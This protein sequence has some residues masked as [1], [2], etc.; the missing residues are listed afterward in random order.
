VWCWWRCVWGWG[1]MHAGEVLST[2]LAKHLSH[3][4]V[5][6]LLLQARLCNRCGSQVSRKKNQAAKHGQAVPALDGEAPQEAQEQPALGASPEEEETAVPAMQ[7]SRQTPEAP[8]AGAAAGADAAA[9]A[10]SSAPDAERKQCA[11][12]GSKTTSAGRWR[13]HPTTWVRRGCSLQCWCCQ[14][15]CG[16]PPAFH[17]LRATCRPACATAAAQKSPAR[18]RSLRQSLERQQPQCME[19]LLAR[20]LSIQCLGRQS[21]QRCFQPHCLRVGCQLQLE[22]QQRP[23]QAVCQ[24]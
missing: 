16:R 17:F 14:Q 6:H 19:R 21:Q 22:M 9:L 4:S 15:G 1:C 10:V 23:G 2:H 3:C 5:R 18:R 7:P 12:C 11:M 13:K 8:F 20:H 24:P